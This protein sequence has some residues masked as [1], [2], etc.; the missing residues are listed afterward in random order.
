MVFGISC[1]DSSVICV[2]GLI[3]VDPRAVGL[4]EPHRHAG[5]GEQAGPVRDPFGRPV[6]VV[7][8]EADA[9]AQFDLRLRVVQS[10]HAM[11]CARWLTP[12]G[13]LG[14]FAENAAICVE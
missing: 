4:R 13:R 7:R 10:L 6:V 12:P 14:K 11:Q 3:D 8:I 9:V 5:A 2:V 1:P